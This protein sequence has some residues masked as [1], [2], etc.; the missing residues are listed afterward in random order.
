MQ[1]Y[2]SHEQQ[3][4]H[5]TAKAPNCADAQDSCPQSAMTS[6]FEVLPLPLPHAST[7]FTTSNPS[8]TSPKT[9]GRN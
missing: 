5:N 4:A 2:K 1:Q 8:I 3:L 6:V 9:Y 7:A